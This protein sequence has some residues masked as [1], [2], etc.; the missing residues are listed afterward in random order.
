MG[1][2][3]QFVVTGLTTGSGYALVGLGIALIVQVTGVISFAQGEFVMVGG[4]LFALLEE[5]GVAAPLAAL[6]ALAAAAA[7]GV[8]LQ[9]VVVPRRGRG[10]ADHTIMLTIGAAIVMEGLALLFVGTQP[11]F[12]RPFTH[13]QALRA[14]G[15]TVTLQNLWVVAVTAAALTVMW[16]FL[17][18]TRTGWAMRA[19]AM[20][21]D[22]ARLVGI[23]PRRM[24]LAVFVLAALLG[25][26]GGIVLAPIQAPDAGIGI[27]LGLK[28]FAAAVIGGLDRP[29]GAVV[30]GLG[31]GVVESVAT[32]YLPGGFSGYANAI[33]FALLLLVLLVRPT[34]VLPHRRAERV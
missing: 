3:L 15:V 2:T 19:T 16:L 17:T 27:P 29:A 7:G 33:A 23:S 18:R 12:A 34:G 31:L 21:R 9:R 6:A 24:S 20:D 25:A 10:G 1:Q 30:G 28:G 26:V 22:A 11:H 13:G 4:L 14:G 32:G 5:N 8:L